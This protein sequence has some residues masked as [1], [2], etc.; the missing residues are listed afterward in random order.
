MRCR[1]RTAQKCRGACKAAGPL[2]AAKRQLTGALA[3]TPVQQRHVADAVAVVPVRST[4]LAAQPALRGVEPAIRTGKAEQQTAHSKAAGLLLRGKTE[5]ALPICSTACWRLRGCKIG[6][7]RRGHSA[8]RQVDQQPKPPA[9]C[10]IGRSAATATAKLLLQ[11]FSVWGPPPPPCFRAPGRKRAPG[12]GRGTAQRVVKVWTL[13][14]WMRRRFASLARHRL[15]AALTRA[16]TR[17]HGARIARARMRPGRTPEAAPLPKVRPRAPPPRQAL[18]RPAAAAA[19]PARPPNG[20]GP[21]QARTSRG[22]WCRGR[23]CRQAGL[24]RRAREH[25]QHLPVGCRWPLTPGI[26]QQA[27]APQRLP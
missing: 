23:P 13:E 16:P 7:T 4:I 26:H 27:A 14:A 6:W 9:G 10:P 19:A 12:A 17:C 11:C 20:A 5:A 2:T 8:G 3:L 25:W 21:L 24:H 1:K 22:C 15:P 18:S